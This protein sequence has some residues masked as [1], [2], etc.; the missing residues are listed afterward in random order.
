[1]HAAAWSSDWPAPA[2][3]NL[4]LRIVGRRADGY[5]E[6]Q[7]VFQFIDRADRIALRVRDDGLIRR[8]T[9]L[10]GVPE[11]DDL[12]V[13]A[14]RLL[15][16]RCPGSPDS[17]ALGVDI[18]IDKQL[19]M[20]GGLGGGSSDAATVLVALNRLWGCRQTREDLARL[21]LELGADVPIFVHGHAAWAEGVGERLQ[22][23]DL[24]QPWYL[25]VV[26]SV[27]VSTAEIFQ[28]P[29]LTRN[30]STITIRDFIAGDRRNDC[31][32]VVRERYPQVA[33]VLNRLADFTRPQLTG[34]GACV[35]GVFESKAGADA[36]LQAL[37][38]SWEGFVARGLN[39]SPL[40]DRA[41][42]D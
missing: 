28:A 30:S 29:E 2:K 36:A 11:Q 18:R 31:L 15:K 34:T 40:L 27:H 26:P 35:F 38:R 37:P 5:H 19:P 42:E 22:A 8:D 6:L 14:A 7:T 3:L 12:M 20:G 10:P 23:V 21:G 32:P 25:V 17:A 16:D 24:E 9:E 39:Q 33:Q 4:M 13:R 1:M 41:I